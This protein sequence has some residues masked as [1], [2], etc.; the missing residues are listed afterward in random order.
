M[1]GVWS[2]DFGG[3]VS[4]SGDWAEEMRLQSAAAAAAQIASTL[5]HLNSP[6]TSA[7][8]T[9]LLPSRRDSLNFTTATA[10]RCPRSG[11]GLF[12]VTCNTSLPGRCTPCRHYET[13]RVANGNLA[14]VVGQ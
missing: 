9:E 1:A 3:Y 2:L 8:Q 11:G 10:D 7:P 5:E 13:L 14:T 4:L 12:T 6:R